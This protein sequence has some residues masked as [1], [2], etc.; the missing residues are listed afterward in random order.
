MTN[1]DPN[2]HPKV[3]AVVYE[4]ENVYV[5]FGDEI[6]DSE[7]EMVEDLFESGER[8]PGKLRNAI[9]S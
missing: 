1:E 9:E 7:K 4:K 5:R 2:T 8:D 3:D 6:T